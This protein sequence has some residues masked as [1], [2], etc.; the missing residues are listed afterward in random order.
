MSIFLL[1]GCRQEKKSG[2]CRARFMFC[3]LKC[4]FTRSRMFCVNEMED[5]F[6]E[7]TFLESFVDTFVKYSRRQKS[8][9]CSCH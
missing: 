4:V 2:L 7:G 3:S 8:F 9:G 5:K 1:S 6:E